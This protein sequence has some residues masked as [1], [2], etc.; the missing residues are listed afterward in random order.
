[1]AKIPGR[2]VTI[3]P[4][5]LAECLERGDTHDLSEHKE[6]PTG[7][8]REPTER[9]MSWRLQASAFGDGQWFVAIRSFELRA[10]APPGVV[11]SRHDPYRS[12][13]HTPQGWR[14]AS[15]RRVSGRRSPEIDWD[16]PDAWRRLTTRQVLQLLPPRW[17]DDVWTMLMQQLETARSFGR[18]EPGRPP[19]EDWARA[20]ALATCWLQGELELAFP[21]RICFVGELDRPGSGELD[22]RAAEAVQQLV[23]SLEPSIPAG[24]PPRGRRA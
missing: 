18:P 7:H 17:H 6:H 10:L 23:A 12:Q 4:R 2:Q 15:W 19:T 11:I 13:D 5:R 14:L 9:D 3:T 24:A 1:M 22:K 20:S 8:G 21:D 16:P